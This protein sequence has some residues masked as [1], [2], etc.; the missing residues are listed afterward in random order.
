MDSLWDGLMMDRVSGGRVQTYAP[1]V[2]IAV[3]L[4]RHKNKLLINI[5]AYRGGTRGGPGLTPT[6]N[7]F[8]YVFIL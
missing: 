6:S 1:K 4:C 3:D 7:F 5:V 8:L 2:T